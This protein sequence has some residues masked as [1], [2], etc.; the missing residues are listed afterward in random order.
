MQTPEAVDIYCFGHVL[1]EMLFGQVLFE[2][3]LSPDLDSLLDAFLPKSIG[4]LYS[5][6]LHSVYDYSIPFY[7]KEMVFLYSRSVTK[8]ALERRH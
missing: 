6:L 8:F 7:Y 5:L 3:T 1:F 2:A 4:I